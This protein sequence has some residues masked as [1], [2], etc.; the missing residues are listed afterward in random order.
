MY[1]CVYTCISAKSKNCIVSTVTAE[2]KKEKKPDEEAQK[3]LCKLCQSIEI[4]TC[5][6]P[7]I[8]L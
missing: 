8:Q 5:H 6:G 1:M 2:Q 3:D 7:N 4:P